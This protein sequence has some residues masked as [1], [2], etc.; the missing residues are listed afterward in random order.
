MDYLSTP[1]RNDIFAIKG[2]SLSKLEDR[3][4]LDSQK[5]ITIYASIHV[6][7][8]SLMI[9]PSLKDTATDS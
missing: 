8:D 2:I 3:R 4:F 9:Y 6:T 5:T 7:L 1:F